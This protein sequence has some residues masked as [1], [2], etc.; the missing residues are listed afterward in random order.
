MLCQRF[1]DEVSII[2]FTLLSNLLVLIAN[3]VILWSLLW[4]RLRFRLWDSCIRIICWGLNKIFWVCVFI[5]VVRIINDLP[6]IKLRSLRN[7]LRRRNYV[8]F[9][10]HISKII[11]CCQILNRFLSWCNGFKFDILRYNDCLIFM[12]SLN[13]R[14]LVYVDLE[15]YL[16]WLLLTC[17]LLIGF[18][19]WTLREIWLL[20]R[21]IRCYD[22]MVASKWL[23]FF[24]SD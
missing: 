3:V 19:G 12:L 23:N 21:G 10:D 11:I 6:L 15:F 18:V 14:C 5:V 1:F 16:P 4:L 2:R 9:V 20:Q 13:W 22:W 8:S 24:Q 7:F 17:C